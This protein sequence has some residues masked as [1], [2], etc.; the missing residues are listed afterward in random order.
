[1]SITQST[2]WIA[3]VS[4]VLSWERGAGK[5]RVIRVVAVAL[6]INVPDGLVALSLTLQ[7]CARTLRFAP[8]LHLGLETIFRPDAGFL[9]PL[10]D[11]LNRET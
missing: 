7:P 9:T 2:G 3:A 6:E 11:L 1:M 5:T 4:L 10:P 8:P